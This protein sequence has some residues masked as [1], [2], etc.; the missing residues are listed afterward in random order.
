M[1]AAF[2]CAADES[3]ANLVRQGDPEAGGGFGRRALVPISDRRLKR[4]PA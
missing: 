2:E 3:A 4:L 1:L